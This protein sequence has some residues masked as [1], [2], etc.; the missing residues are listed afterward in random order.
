VLVWNNALL[1]GLQSRVSA[2]PLFEARE[3]SDNLRFDTTYAHTSPVSD[4]PPDSVFDASVFTDAGLEPYDVVLFLNTNGNTI[5]DGMKDVHRAA[6]RD[7][8]EKKA[9]GFV[10]IYFASFGYMSDSWLWY[11]DF[12][13]A[14]FQS[15]TNV[16]TP[17]TAEPEP[18]AT[19][20]ILQAAALP[21]PWNRSEGWLSFSRDPRTSPIPGVTVLLTCHDT[22]DAT[23]R[24]CAWVHEMPPAPDAVDGRQGRMFYSA[25]GYLPSAFE[26]EKLMD[27]VVAGI[28]WAAHRL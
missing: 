18:P 22:M 3:E 10:G 4:G 14:R 12:I 17:G 7:F 15:L 28:R 6:L 20:P 25:F 27:F 23:R 1:R 21:S 19:H 26:E 16:N 9:R 5:D 13:G 2:I 24:P 8:I 11:T